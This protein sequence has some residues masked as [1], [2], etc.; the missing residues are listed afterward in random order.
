MHDGLPVCSRTRGQQYVATSETDCLL[1]VKC[2]VPSHISL[3]CQ[4]MHISIVIAPL[5]VSDCVSSQVCYRSK[6]CLPTCFQPKA[7]R[8][9]L[10]KLQASTEGTPRRQTQDQQ[11]DN[12]R[13]A[14]TAFLSASPFAAWSPAQPELP[15]PPG[16][17]AHQKPP[18]Q[19]VSRSPSGPAR[20]ASS[21]IPAG[22]LLSTS[23]SLLTTADNVL[24]PTGRVLPTR[25]DREGGLAP[26]SSC[27]D[28]GHID[29]HIHTYT[30]TYT[31]MYIVK[32]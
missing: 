8:S 12:A 17:L 15:L 1:Q 11:W 4:Y 22:R 26:T 13:P 10:N 21:T 18:W 14:S 20:K 32:I 27:Q 23:A 6:L 24:P 31:Y 28:V 16:D 29:S 5:Q 2:W 7:S 30:Y 25:R 3:K 19:P 9:L